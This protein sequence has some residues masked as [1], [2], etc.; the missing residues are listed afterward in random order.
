V[1]ERKKFFDRESKKNAVGEMISA[2]K[3]FVE[4]KEGLLDGR[5]R[6][7]KK[8]PSLWRGSN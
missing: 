1:G 5:G 6:H 4:E 7:E 3:E 8:I 2:G